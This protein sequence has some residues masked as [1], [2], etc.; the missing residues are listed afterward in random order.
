MAFLRQQMPYWTC[1]TDHWVLLSKELVH[2]I[3][4]SLDYSQTESSP[5]R[6]KEIHKSLI[7]Q[8]IRGLEQIQPKYIQISKIQH[9]TIRSEFFIVR[10]WILIIGF[11]MLLNNQIS[12]F[13]PLRLLL[14]PAFRTKLDA[15]EW[16]TR[17]RSSN[18]RL[19]N[20][21]LDLGQPNIC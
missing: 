8:M 4:H 11:Q 18:E 15:S 17:S 14:L 21:E 2:Y 7:F 5:N 1:C 19:V 12:P 10:C 16:T 13:Y 9:P 6:K 3:R 20:S